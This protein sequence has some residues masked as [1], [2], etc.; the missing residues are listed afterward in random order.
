[1]PPHFR[2][3]KLRHRPRHPAQIEAHTVFHRRHIQFFRHR[4]VYMHYFSE[5]VN[6]N[7]EFFFE[8]NALKITLHSAS[9][10]KSIP[11]NW[12]ATI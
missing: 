9:D 10:R 2:V 11:S 4:C 3:K 1:V 7:F 6:S 5:S 8:Q 12:I